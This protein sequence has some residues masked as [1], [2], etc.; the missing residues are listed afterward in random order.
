M[1]L[2]FT[3]SINVPFES[4]NRNWFQTHT[5]CKVQNAAYARYY[6]FE[7]SDVLK[8]TKTLAIIITLL[9]LVVH[10]FLKIIQLSK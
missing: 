7:T 6:L 9:P 8:I 5:V 10:G 2:I 1:S 4:L 3:S